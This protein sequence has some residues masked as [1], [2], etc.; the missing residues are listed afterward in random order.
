MIRYHSSD[1]AIMRHDK[2]IRAHLETQGFAH[3]EPAID[4]SARDRELLEQEFSAL[5]PDEFAP[6]GVR[7]FRRYGNG[8]I[9][10]WANRK[11]VFWIPPVTSGGI[12]RAGYDQGSNNPEHAQ[13]RYFNALSEECRTSDI[14]QQLILDD[15][16]HTFW[17]HVGQAF[18]IYFGVH[19]VKLQAHDSVERGISSPDCFHQ[20]GEPFTFA[21]L[22]KRSPSTAGGHNY[23]GRT[24]V[25]NRPLGE[26]ASD[27]IIAD[28]TLNNFLESFAVHDPRVC[29]YV[30]PIRRDANS[31]GVAERCIML[32]DFSQTGQKI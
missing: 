32:I 8:I 7:R 28:F 29:H 14:L 21:H 4:Y 12:C 26:V 17:K 2:S 18:P 25:R 9:I 30:D 23:I 31:E 16:S 15:F 19:F 5:E 6:S 20:D 3:Y 1:K 11:Q 10:P 22:V 27:D 24:S 13:I